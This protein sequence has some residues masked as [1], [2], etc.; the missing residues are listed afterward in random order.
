V[1]TL[2]SLLLPALA[3]FSS[4]VI[5]PAVAAAGEPQ[6]FVEAKKALQQI[7]KAHPD[8]PSFYCGCDIRYQGKKMSPDWAS[9]GYQPRKQATR[10]SRIEWEHIVPAW[11]FGHQHQCWQAGGRKNCVATDKVFA[12]MEGDMHNLVPAVGEVNGDRANFRYSDWGAQADQYGHCSMVVDFAGKRVQPPVRSR[13]AIART[14]LY[15]ARQYK[16]RIAEQQL[17]LFTAWDRRYPVTPWEC[18]RDALIA[19]A[20]GNHNPFV[21]E[22]CH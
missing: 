9:C 16:L 18:Q 10:A 12:L 20:Q 13:G 21:E 7:Y 4:V 17:K 22:Q 5:Q 11:E 19:Q 14:Y 2:L 6:T 1:R 3:V 8:Q 15:M